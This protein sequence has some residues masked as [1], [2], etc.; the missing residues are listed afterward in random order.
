MKKTRMFIF[1]SVSAMAVSCTSAKEELISQREQAGCTACGQDG[2]V[3][4]IGMVSNT[5]TDYYDNGLDVTGS[6]IDE[7]STPNKRYLF[8]KR[9]GLKSTV[10]SYTSNLTGS[11][12]VEGVVYVGPGPSNANPGSKL[13]VESC[14]NTTNLNQNGWVAD[15]NKKIVDL[16]DGSFLRIEAEDPVTVSGL[17]HAWYKL[18][19]YDANAQ[20]QGYV[21]AENGAK[22]DWAMFVPGRITLTNGESSDYAS[23]AHNIYNKEDVSGVT[24]TERKE[25]Q[26]LSL[27]CKFKTTDCLLA[28]NGVTTAV[29]PALLVASPNCTGSSNADQTCAEDNAFYNCASPTCSD[30]YQNHGESDV[31][32]GGPC[33]Q[34]CAVSKN[35]GQ[36][37]DCESLN[38]VSG[39]CQSPS[40][41]NSKK[42]GVE[43]AVDCGGSNACSRCSNGQA[44]SGDS[45][46]QSGHCT[47]SVCTVLGGSTLNTP[48]V[49]WPDRSVSLTWSDP[50][51]NEVDVCVY[52]SEDGG[53]S[54]FQVQCLGANATSWTDSYPCISNPSSGSFQYKIANCPDTNCS[55][56]T[57]YS[58]VVSQSIEARTKTITEWLSNSNLWTYYTHADAS[59]NPYEFTISPYSHSGMS[60][61]YVCGYS[62]YSSSL[63]WK[64]TNFYTGDSTC[65]GHGGGYVMGY[66][67]DTQVTGSVPLYFQY[68]NNSSDQRYQISTDYSFMNYRYLNYGWTQPAVIGYVWSA[69]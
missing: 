29:A 5:V 33:N 7:G 37:S 67:S 41:S 1:M 20:E 39:V 17:T 48:S 25:N 57:F 59:A 46:C 6:L 52:R 58:N 26:K 13:K 68:S 44:C 18:K 66:M 35:C 54:F 38:C 56:Q 22:Q 12:A 43:T 28:V 3:N 23:W 32:C 34:K 10:C 53:T 42:D 21:C 8:I 2:N 40:C 4:K 24:V 31:D 60:P 64:W 30:T 62:W 51:S 19:N 36:D 61:L 16:Q 45:D 63:G 65:W 27:S 11:A 49:N 50:N 47:N 69:P 14:N 15:G 55:G 9:Y